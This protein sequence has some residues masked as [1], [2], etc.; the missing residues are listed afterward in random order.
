MATR[1]SSF[2]PLIEFGTL[3]ALLLIAA[4][5][6]F[7]VAGRDS[8][9]LLP[10]PL[11]A[12]L[13][14]ANLVPAM[15]MMVLIARRVAVRRAAQ[16][17][18]GGRGRLHVRLVALFSVIAAVPTLLVV[19]FASLLFQSGTNFWFSER[20][21]GMLE[22]A[23]LIAQDAYKQE[24]DRVSKETLTMSGDLAGYL[25]E[26]PIDS[27]AFAE[28]FGRQVWYRNLSE[29]VILNASPESGV[30]ALA[31]VNPYDRPLEKVVTPQM[32]AALRAGQDSVSVPSSDRLG[33]VAPLAVGENTF[34]YAARVFD[35][36]MTEQIKRAEAVL[37]DYR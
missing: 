12:A 36:Q 11:V 34:L 3:A 17:P 20:S 14:V 31:L 8:D 16:S 2:V 25:Q 4:I 21:R 7:V 29:A 23:A 18:I 9:A 28:G 37:G 1:R 32:L 13:L 22:N 35:P 15:A 19:I 24:R 6:Y 27:P 5:S 10:P 30:Q 26:V 33:A